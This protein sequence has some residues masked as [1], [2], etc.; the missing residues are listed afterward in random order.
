MA[1]TNL[2][3]GNLHRAVS[4]STRSGQASMGQL[5]GNTVNGSLIGFATDGITVTVPTYTYIVESTEEL[6][7]HN[8]HLAQQ[9]LYF[10]LKFNNNITIILV[11]LIMQ[12]LQQV[13]R[14]YHLVLRYFQ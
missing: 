8:F 3:L 12:I 2:S 1:R 4:G 10:I 9:V 11:H 5:G 13:V 6:S 7:R 14:Q